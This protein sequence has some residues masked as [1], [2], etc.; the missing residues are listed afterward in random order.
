MNRIFSTALLTTAISWSACTDNSAASSKNTQ[1]SA[2]T[3]QMSTANPNSDTAVQHNPLAGMTAAYLDMK[4]GLAGD[5]GNEAAA[6]GTKFNTA[7]DQVNKSVMSA[8]QRKSFEDI[9]DDAREMAEHIS[10]NAGKI[11]HQREHFDMLSKDMYDLLKVFG[12]GQHLY[13]DYCPMYNNNKGAIWLS[14]T[15][16]IKNPY[17]GKQQPDCGTV[18]E[19]MK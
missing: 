4:N 15:K 11:A 14:E 10:T 12:T 17:M 16:A 5:N 9:A 2:D 19:E 18:K 1:A 6:A 3:V 8:D 13:E 7:L